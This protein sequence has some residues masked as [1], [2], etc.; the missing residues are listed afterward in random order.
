MLSQKQAEIDGAAKH[1]ADRDRKLEPV[2]LAAVASG[3]VEDRTKDE[4]HAA[5]LAG[6]PNYVMDLDVRCHKPGCG[7][8]LTAL[9]YVAMINDAS[10]PVPRFMLWIE[11][12][13]PVCMAKRKTIF[14]PM[15]GMQA[16]GKLIAEN[17]ALW[18]SWREEAEAVDGDDAQ[19]VAEVA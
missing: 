13:C 16:Q 15:V 1:L 10:N 17:D 12:Q 8:P 5:A 3:G 14:D 11:G 7:A 2:R 4:L 6:A 19:E 9:S 18:R